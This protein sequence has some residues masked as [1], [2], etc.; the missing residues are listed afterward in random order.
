MIIDLRSDTVTKPTKEMLDAMMQAEVGDDVFGEEPTVNALEKKVAAMFGKEAALFCPSG[1]M[2]N[3]IAIKVH[4]QPGDEVLCDVTAHIYNYEGGGMASNS[5]VQ[6]KLLQGDRGRISVEQVK[7]NIN[8]SYDW[9]TNTSL[10]CIENTGNRAGGSYYS[11]QQMKELSEVCKSYK[12]N[13]HLDGARIF[14]AIVENDY[15]PADI[16]PLFDSV[17]I[18]LSKGLGA[19]VGSLLVG[20]R[21]FITKARRVRKVFGGGM[22]QAGYL[23]A[24]GIYALDH[25][26]DRLNEDHHRAKHL[27]E[28]LSKLSYVDSILPVDTNIVIFNLKS[29]VSPDSFLTSL[30]EQG[31]KAAGFGQQAIRFVTHLDFTDD[32][33]MKVEETLKNMTWK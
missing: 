25:H 29:S 9:L 19:P 31:I 26:V 24:A 5:G 20:D 21:E 14:N 32:M 13:F 1:T 22:R 8:P 6:A 12:L 30:S 33:L 23:A 4:T 17:S 27:S 18:C 28:V 15:T 2:T 3:Q 16:G 10:V 11:L 7:Q